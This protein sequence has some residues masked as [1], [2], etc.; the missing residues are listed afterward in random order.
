VRL[1][2]SPATSTPLKEQGPSVL[3]SRQFRS[4]HKLQGLLQLKPASNGVT[5]LPTKGALLCGSG[6]R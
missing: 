6:A 3:T 2:K 4:L 5:I 1:D